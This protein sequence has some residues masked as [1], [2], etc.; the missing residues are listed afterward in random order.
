MLLIA[1]EVALQLHMRAPIEDATD[2]MHRGLVR[3]RQTAQPRGMLLDQLPGIP[4]LP[5]GMRQRPRRQQPAEILVT[6]AVLH[7]N[8][9]TVVSG[10]QHKFRPHPRLHPRLLRRPIKP[11]RPIHP[12]RIDERHRRQISLRRNGHQILWQRRAIEEGK[13][14]RGAHLGIRTC[15][16]RCDPLPPPRHFLRNLLPIRSTPLLVDIRNVVVL[17]RQRNHRRPLLHL[18]LLRSRRIV[19]DGERIQVASGL[20]SVQGLMI[21]SPRAAGGKESTRGGERAYATQS[22]ICCCLNRSRATTEIDS[23]FICTR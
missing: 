3:P 1:A 18:L 23:C 19:G 14:R 22:T 6:G 13:R 7:E 5:F 10:L 2:P 20:S 12:V 9:Q 21:L 15:V 8:R 11:R 16:P 4:S 17:H